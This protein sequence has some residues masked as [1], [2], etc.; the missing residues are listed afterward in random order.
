[1]QWYEADVR[2]LEQRTRCSAIPVRPAVFY[3]SSTLRL[4]PTLAEDLDIPVALNLGFGGSTLEACAH[5]FDRIFTGLDP[6]S[7]T[8]YAGDNDLGDGQSPAKVLASFRLLAAKIRAKYPAVPLFFISI[9]PSPARQYLFDAIRSTNASI[10][11]EIALLPNAAFIDI[12]PAMLSEAGRPRP[13]LFMEDGLHM[14]PLGY[15]IWRGVLANYRNR[16]FPLD[17]S[18]CHETALSS[19][20]SAPGI[21]QVVQPSA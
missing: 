1:M 18:D 3:G 17:F 6:Q 13:E 8:I 10:Q 2:Q 19:P 9:K 5:F 11:Q 12:F 4:W 7:I 21:S 15:G 14:N 20:S 16:I